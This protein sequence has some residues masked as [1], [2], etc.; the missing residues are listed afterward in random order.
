MTELISRLENIRDTRQEWKVLHKLSEIVLIV[1]LALLAN[2]DEWEIIEDFA[3][4]NEEF[5]RK[6]LVLANGIPSHDTIQRVMA[7]IEPK[8]MQ[9]VQLAWNE[10]VNSEE[11]EKL[12][13]ILNIDGKTIRGSASAK[14]KAL[15]IVSAYS[16]ED[17]IS[18]GQIAV[19]EKENEIV[20]I[21]DLLDEISVKDSVVT[22]DAMGCQTDIAEKIISKGADYVLALKGNQKNLHQDVIDY[23]EDPEFR[24]KMKE[25][26]NYYKT[27]EK[28]HG[29]FETR[30]YYQTEDIDWLSGKGKWKNLKSIGMVETTI[31]KGG[32]KTKES[33]YFISSLA[34]MILLFAKAVRGHWAIES[35]HWHLDVTFR[36]DSNKTLDST[37]AQNLNILRKLALRILKLV[38]VGKKRSLKRKRYIICVNSSKFLEKIMNI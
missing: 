3:Y 14:K 12:K 7:I 2:A 22:I 29:Q 4:A 30:E 37:A 24:Q 34:V 1:L 23:F 27:A 38:D 20:A 21:P 33:R 17:G 36:E 26:G 28:A 11:G 15:H 10:I 19:D 9:T 13:K 18:F 6:H 16:N 5:L 31:E 35:M 8:E 32:V 25:E